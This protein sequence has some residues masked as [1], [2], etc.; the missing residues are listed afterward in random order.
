MLKPEINEI[1]KLFKKDA[2]IIS[3][4]TACYVDYEKNIKLIS[5]S[6]YHLL[7]EEDC[8]KYEEIFKK[9]LSGSLGKNLLNIEIDLEEELHGEA[10]K[11]LMELRKSKLEDTELNEKFFKKIIDNF[12]Y[13]ENYYIVLIDIVYDIPMKTKDKLA[14]DDASEESYH[15][16]LCSICPVSLSKPC[17]SYHAETDSIEHRVRDWEVGE[18]MKAFLFPTFSDRSTDIHT[19]LYFS[20]KSDNISEELIDTLFA[21]K[22]PIP[23]KQQKEIIQTEIS[24]ALGEDCEY[25][26]VSRLHENLSQLIEEH[27]NSEAPLSLDKQDMVKL[28]AKSGASDEAVKAYESSEDTDI[29]VVA[30]NIIGVKSLD[31]KSEGIV[32]KAKPEYLPYIKTQLID[33]RQCLVIELNDDIELNGISIKSR[34]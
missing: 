6:A 7:A 28:M 8:F 20:K 13:A 31:I 17:L 11:L 29:S 12:I 23:A 25:E 18:P 30:D 9:S 19:A 21:A 34:K 3:R 10:H 15:A 16:L 22:A 24:K 4:I 2:N 32:L 27:D 33:G 5:N 14:L 1:K 26:V